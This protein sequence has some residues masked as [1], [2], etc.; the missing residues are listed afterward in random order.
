MSDAFEGAVL[1]GGRSSRMGT[2]KAL[3]DVGA[4]PL[5]TAV[6]RAVRQAGAARVRVIG[7]DPVVLG[8]LGI[9]VESDEQ[10]GQGPLPAIAA[11]LRHAEHDVVFVA[12][13]DLAAPSSDA[14]RAVVDACGPLVDAAVPVVG[15]RAQYLHAAYRRHL[16]PVFDAAL[17]SGERRLWSVVG[18]CRTSAPT[19][20]EDATADLDT[21]ADLAAWNSRSAGVEAGI[22]PPSG[23]D[24]GNLKPGRTGPIEEK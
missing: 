8:P 18:R 17:A 13:C 24:P 7:G 14:V 11:A 5:V 10:P 20:G 2:D 16:A 3:L 21:P 6:V 9:E 4:G 1:C 12:A 15:G 22:D 19:V 23:L